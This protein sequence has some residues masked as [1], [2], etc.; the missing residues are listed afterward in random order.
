MSSL[1]QDFPKDANSALRAYAQSASFTRY[2]YNNYGGSGLKSLVESYANGLDC[3]RGALA[4][5]GEN[6]SSLESQWLQDTYGASK[7]PAN[8]QAENKLAPWLALLAVALA[9][10]LLL[11]LSRRKKQNDPIR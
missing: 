6:L 8:T 9:G 10:P 4:A 2:L 7:K 5:L 1:C 11:M 3:E